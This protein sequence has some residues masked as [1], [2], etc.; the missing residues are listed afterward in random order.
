MKTA[1]L[2]APLTKLKKG[3]FL[4]L[5]EE[6]PEVRAKFEESSEILGFDLASQFYSDDEDLVNKGTIARPSIVTIGC[7]IY[8][9]IKKAVPEPDFYLGPS[10]GQVSAIH[11]S[12][13]LDFSESI[14]MISAM[15]ETEAADP[16]NKKYG[17]YFFYNIKNEILVELMNDV[18]NQ[19]YV[20]EPCVYVTENQMIING[21]SE[22]LEELSGKVLDY[23]GLGVPIPY[24]PPGHCSL[25]N[26]VKDTIA[27][28]L[29]PSINLKAPRKPLISNVTAT[30]LMSS[31]Q[32]ENEL[33]NQY[34][35]PV[36]WYESLKYLKGQGV[37]DLIVLGP[38]NF[39]SKS[40]HFTELSF[41]VDAILTA[42]DIHKKMEV[43]RS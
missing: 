7:A 14:R 6:F 33:I 15:C 25:L 8:D 10:L 38:G 18:R 32:I 24:G 22:S 4:D 9:L 28:E 36:R 31:L 29:M 19:G 34:T 40:L 39:V 5:Y 13:S 17:V 26:N 35:M 43:A 11:C 30:P 21:D 42:E 2:F 41:N 12:G 20:L 23:G 1:M 16:A 37:N 27:Q 3:S